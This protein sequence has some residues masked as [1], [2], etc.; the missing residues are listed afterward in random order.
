MRGIL[1]DGTI[2]M[3]KAQAIELAQDYLD[4]QIEC[5]ADP[6]TA[7]VGVLR[8]DD[9]EVI[10]FTVGYGARDVCNHIQLKGGYKDRQQAERLEALR[11]R[12]G[13]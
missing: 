10:W 4:M 5:G 8:P 6:E 3:N 13:L 9:S 2:A 7:Y 11:R 1:E 12:L